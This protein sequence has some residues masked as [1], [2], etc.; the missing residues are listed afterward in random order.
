MNDERI[1]K[2]EEVVDKI[3]LKLEKLEYLPEEPFDILNQ[4]VDSD[5]RGVFEFLI[6]LNQIVYDTEENY[7]YFDTLNISPDRIIGFL[8][9]RIKE[10]VENGYGTFRWKHIYRRG[11]AG[12]LF[13]SRYATSLVALG[14]LARERR[15]YEILDKNFFLNFEERIP[16]RLEDIVTQEDIDLYLFNKGVDIKKLLKIRELKDPR[17]RLLE[18]KEILRGLPFSGSDLFLIVYGKNRQKYSTIRKHPQITKLL[19]EFFENEENTVQAFREFVHGRDWTKLIK[20]RYGDI[21]FSGVDLMNYVKVPIKFDAKD[22]R[23]VGILIGDAQIHKVNSA[24]VIVLYG[25][26][27]D[28]KFYRTVIV[29]YVFHSHN[30]NAN[31]YLCGPQKIPSVRIASKLISSWFRNYILRNIDSNTFVNKYVLEGLVAARGTINRGA[32]NIN[33][34]D[35]RRA[36]FVLKLFENIGYSPHVHAEVDGDYTRY[37]F[38]VTKHDT[39]SFLEDITLLNPKHRLYLIQSH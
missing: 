15:Y 19:K 8:L 22:Y 28:L 31:I 4:F 10:R 37:M 35:K 13:L 23:W 9:G 18:S 38:Y 5:L 39:Q 29:P 14:K 25:M 20:R 30:Y 12:V 7:F 33:I 24:D 36:N 6:E 32:L 1:E 2:L 3:N 17:N 21:S 34:R 16:K 26:H 11:K 27:N